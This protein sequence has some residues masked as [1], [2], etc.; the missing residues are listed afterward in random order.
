MADSEITL[1]NIWYNRAFVLIPQGDIASASAAYSASVTMF[2][3]GGGSKFDIAYA[4]RGQAAALGRVGRVAEAEPLYEEAIEAFLDTGAFDEAARTDI[5]LIMATATLGTPLTPER[6]AGSRD[7]IARASPAD[8]P[9]LLMNLGNIE[10]A[11]GSLE[12]AERTFIEAL[13]LFVAAGRLVD[14]ARADLSRAAILRRLGHPEQSI[15]VATSARAVVAAEG[16]SQLVAHA[17]HN[18]ALSYRDLGQSSQASEKI[19]MAVAALDVHRHALPSAHDRLALTVTTYPKLFEVAFETVGDTSSDLLAA[20]IERSRVQPVP[21]PDEHGRLRYAPPPPVAVRPDAPGVDGKGDPKYLTDRIEASI[22]GNGH[23]LS[24]AL[25]GAELIRCHI[26]ASKTQ[27]DR[28]TF[29]RQLM[30]EV[31]N[32][33]TGG[34]HVDSQWPVAAEAIQMKKLFQIASGPLLNDD[35]LAGRLAATLPAAVIE[36]SPLTQRSAQELLTD[37]ADMLLPPTVVEAIAGAEH[38]KI[39][40]APPPILG[41][42]PWAALMVRGECLIERSDLDLSLPVGLR[43][44]S[45]RPESAKEGRVWVSDPTGDLPFSRRSPE[46][47]W[48]VLSATSSP[49]ATKSA[50]LAQLALLP[51]VLVLRG[52]VQSGLPTDPAA[53]QILLSCGDTLSTLDLLHGPG[54][55]RLCILLGCDSLGGRTGL[56]WTGICT[57]FIWAGASQVVTTLWPVVDDSIQ[58]QLD[59]D[60]VSALLAAAGGSALCKWQRTEAHR[61]RTDAHGAQAPFRWANLVE[62][63]T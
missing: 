54:A 52:H 60:L 22:D 63:R 1:G 5:G 18:L 8:L 45:N 15:E 16:R 59:L 31:T 36:R 23:R 13:E 34:D 33:L 29:D 51:E 50:V 40:I 58:E 26:T 44:S 41:Q 48:S 49:P 37:L 25:C 30:D 9:D 27:V 46:T 20:L 62:C 28:V 21:T 47:G 14:A 42:I 3:E 17:D 7:R 19:L 38:L 32:A 6:L 43:S 2:Q 53:A 24:W 39:E 55:P 61:W 56:E 57:G 4:L 12:K 35:T 10:A 11:D